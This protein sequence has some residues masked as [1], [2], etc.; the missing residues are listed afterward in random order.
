M[1]LPFVFAACITCAS[2]SDPTRTGGPRVTDPAP[3][4]QATLPLVE[5]KTGFPATGRKKG[6][7]RKGRKGRRDRGEKKGGSGS[8]KCG[9]LA[10][11]YGIPK[12]ECRKLS[13]DKKCKQLAQKHGLP[14]NVCKSL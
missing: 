14:A 10:E 11:R 6:E 5:V 7:G 9:R 13:G 1:I 12:G 2:H 3:P 8:G 4:I